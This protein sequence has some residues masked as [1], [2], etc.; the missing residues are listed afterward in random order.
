MAQLPVQG[1]VENDFVSL[2]A[3]VDDADPISTVA[4]QIASHAIGIRVAEQDRPL[5]VRHRGV[6]LDNDS[7]LAQAGCTPMEVLEVRYA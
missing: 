5:R 7:T 6:F 3:V 2:L 4:Q 1:I